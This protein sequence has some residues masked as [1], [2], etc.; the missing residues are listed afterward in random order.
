MSEPKSQEIVS[1]WKAAGPEKWF[2]KKFEFDAEITRL[3]LPTLDLAGDGKLDNWLDEPTGSLA[4][5][6]VLDQFPRNIYRDSPRAFDFDL[7]ARS[8]AEIVIRRNHDAEFEMPLRRFFYLPYMHSE[9]LEDQMKSVQLCEASHDDEGVKFARVHA[10]VIRKFGRFPHRNV[11]LGRESRP[12][13][14]AFLAD[15]GFS[16]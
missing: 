8:C 15:G 11:V 13:E 16:G 10:D 4:L 3:F 12:E 1:F 9:V 2:E 14:I 7:R 5:L 6:L